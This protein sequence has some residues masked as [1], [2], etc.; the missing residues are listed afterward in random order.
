MKILMSSSGLESPEKIKCQILN[1]MSI[2][3]N[4]LHYIMRKILDLDS[5][6]Q[7]NKLLDKLNYFVKAK[8]SI[9]E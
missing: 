3:K 8:Q 9:E 7:A 1:T 5:L 2:S 6:A 4:R